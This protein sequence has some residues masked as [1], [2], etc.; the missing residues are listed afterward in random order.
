MQNSFYD[1]QLLS[2]QINF[3]RRLQA[4]ETAGNSVLTLKNGFKQ[5]CFIF[6]DG[7]DIFCY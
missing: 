7:I 6:C 1:L 5:I 2:E 4:P 3:F